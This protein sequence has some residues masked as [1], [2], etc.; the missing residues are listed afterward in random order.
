MVNVG[1]RVLHLQTL[2]LK[3]PVLGGYLILFIITDSGFE[4][5]PTS[6]EPAILVFSPNGRLKEPTVPFAGTPKR[7]GRYK[8]RY[9]SHQFFF[10]KERSV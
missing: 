3:T 8:G 2:Q 6:K 7:T 10:K 4:N 1:F 9:L 5:V